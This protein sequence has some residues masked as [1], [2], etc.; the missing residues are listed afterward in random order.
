MVFMGQ[1]EAYRRYL[2]ETGLRNDQVLHAHS[3]DAVRGYDLSI[4]EL[5]R[6]DGFV[7]EESRIL[8]VMRSLGLKL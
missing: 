2:S 3:V 6:D 4:A 1:Y 5:V 7:R 8:A